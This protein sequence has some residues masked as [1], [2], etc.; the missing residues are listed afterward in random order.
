MRRLRP[1]L[2][3]CCHATSRRTSFVASDR[4]PSS[5]YRGQNYW[6]TVF[7]RIEE[8]G[9]EA[10][11]LRTNSARQKAY[12]RYS[13]FIAFTSRQLMMLFYQVVCKY[14]LPVFHTSA[15]LS[16][17]GELTADNALSPAA[18]NTIE[19]TRCFFV[20]FLGELIEWLNFSSRYRHG[21]RRS[22]PNCRLARH[23]A[24]ACQPCAW[25][26]SEE[27]EIQ[28]GAK[29]D[30]HWWSRE[31]KKQTRRY[32][33]II[34]RTIWTRHASVKQSSV[35]RLWLITHLSQ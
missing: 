23:Y 21:K 9:S 34:Y 6:N 24:H 17:R 25:G 18:P 31:V 16:R 22:Q 11:S 12:M 26:G 3:R 33:G 1:L 10:R 29:S 20:Y 15:R 13:V 30:T 14:I 27:G 2:R 4:I 28:I 19:S 7:F 35:N 8:V 5:V 32:S